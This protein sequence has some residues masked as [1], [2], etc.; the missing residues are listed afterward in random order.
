MVSVDSG[1]GHAGAALSVP[2]VVLYGAE[3]PL[4]W[5]P[6]S[7]SGSPVVAAGGAPVSLRADQVSVDTVFNAWRTVAGYKRA[8]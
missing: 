4:Y 1:P 5:L 7:P 8:A 6:R 2:L 3:P